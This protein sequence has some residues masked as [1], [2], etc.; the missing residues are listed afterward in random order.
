MRK[1]CAKFCLVRSIL[2]AAH[3]KGFLVAIEIASLL[4]DLTALA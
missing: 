3:L 2:G 4:S 1:T